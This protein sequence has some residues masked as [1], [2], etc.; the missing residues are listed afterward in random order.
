M[1]FDDCYQICGRHWIYWDKTAAVRICQLLRTVLSS[2]SILIT[3]HQENGN[4][5][6]KQ[7]LKWF[8]QELG[9]GSLFININN[10]CGDSQRKGRPLSGMAVVAY[11]LYGSVL[12]PAA[13]IMSILFGIFQGKTDASKLW[14]FYCLLPDA[15]WVVGLSRP[16]QETM[17]RL[18]C[19]SAF[20]AGF[21]YSYESIFGKVLVG[22]PILLP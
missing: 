20:I 9:L 2:L 13:A 19:R 12:C 15:C 7:D 10:L 16:M 6:L 1:R 17:G 18:R 4:W 21:G 8:S 22:K 3:D 5:R 11:A 14:R